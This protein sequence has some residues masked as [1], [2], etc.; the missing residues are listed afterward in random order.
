MRKLLFTRLR[1]SR[2]R[3]RPHEMASSLRNL[4]SLKRKHN[5]FATRAD[6]VALLGDHFR[7]VDTRW[8]HLS[9]MA[10]WYESIF[11]DLPEHRPFAKELR[12]P[13]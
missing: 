5:D 8:S 4:A 3:T 7:G 9:Q 2:T 6:L 1:R 11:V 13:C 10:D 12:P